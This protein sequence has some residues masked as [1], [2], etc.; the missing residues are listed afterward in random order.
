MSLIACGQVNAQSHD[1]GVDA[2]S[3][4]SADAAPDAGTNASG[5][6][7]VQQS[8]G[9]TPSA[10]TISATFSAATTIDDLLVIIGASTDDALQMMNITGG[11]VSTWSIAA[12]S[13]AHANIEIW[14]GLVTTSTDEPVTIGHSRQGDLR[15]NVS[16]WRGLATQDVL[17]SANALDGTS[18]SAS[19][20]PLDTHA[21]DLIVLGAANQGSNS[22]IGSPSEG[23]WS[24][25]K[26][27]ALGDTAVQ[28]SWYQ[29][30]PATAAVQPMVPTTGEGWDA[31]IAAFKV[32]P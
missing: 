19:A 2:P 1:S 26:P 23:P 15:L 24:A 12:A 20:Q 30:L 29:T 11:G 25:L 18:S 5:A 22:S 28:S 31:A 32:A 8:V 16:E 21:P 4:P 3:V 14:Y 27:I 10:L 6:A 13:A 9:S 17:D 7:F